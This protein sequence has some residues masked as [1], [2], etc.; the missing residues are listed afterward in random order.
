MQGLTIWLGAKYLLAGEVTLPK[1]LSV[2][3][4]ILI[5]A[6]SAGGVAPNAQAISSASAASSKIFNTIDRVSPVDSASLDGE[7]LDNVKGKVELRNIMHIY[8]SRPGSVVAHNISFVAAAGTTTAIVGA[9]G[10]GKS[11]IVGLLERFYNPVAG[12]VLLDDCDISTLNLKWLRQQISLV[13]QEPV[14]FHTTISYN[15][16]LGLIGTKY[17]HGSAAVK[18]KLVENAA[19]MA[20]A[21]TFISTLPKAYDTKVGER[22]S[23]LSGGQRQRI[24]IAR[25]VISD[26]KLLL[27]DEATSSLDANAESAVQA[28]L[29]HAALGRTTII[30]AH[31]LSTIRS[32]HN[33][34]VL[35]QG[36][37]AEQGSHD[38]LM[39][40]QGLYYNLVK[41]QRLEV[42]R[43]DN[44]AVASPLSSTSENLSSITEKESRRWAFV[45]EEEDERID[46]SAYE[47]DPDDMTVAAK[48]RLGRP[49]ISQRKE[50]GH[51]R[52]DDRKAYST[53]TLLKL[54]G[55]FNRQERGLMLIGLGCSIIA[56]A[57]NPIQAV[58]FAHS[59]V[60]LS[61]PD[62]E[63]SKIHH[64]ADFWAQMFLMLGLVQ[65]LAYSILGLAF[66]TCSE[67][68]IHRARDRAFRTLLRQDIAFFDVEENG[69]GA[70]T[71][72]LATQVTL[73]AG[74]SGAT[75]GTLLVTVTTLVV[76]I[77][78]SCAIGWKLALVCSATVPILIG[79][80]F[81]RVSMLAR[82]EVTAKN[83]SE[84]SA[85]YACE[86]ISS[87]RTVASLTREDEIKQSYNE[88][89]LTQ[90]RKSLFSSLKSSIV[91]AASQ[92]LE[93]LCIALTFWYGGSLVAS[94]EYIELQFYVCFSA[95]IYGALS[96]GV[97]FSFGPDIA[98]G[99]QAAGA[100]KTLFD[101]T[102]QIDWW[103]TEGEQIRDMRGAIEFN[104][105][106][107]H[108][109][110]RSEQ[111]VLNG[112]SFTVEAGQKVALVG[113]SGCGKSTTIALLER[114]Y[115][116]VAGVISVDGI[117]ISTLQLA[118]Y[119]KTIALVSQDLTLFQGT[120]KEN[121][122]LGLE[123]QD[124]SQQTIVQACIDA[125]IYDFI[126]SLTHYARP[127]SLTC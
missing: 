44:L 4:A 78:L 11:T 46:G 39:E 1:I 20:N 50:S 111:P 121:L 18:R 84:M 95:V 2:L 69:S 22:G 98:K 27:L 74:L 64:D 15:I 24:A 102:P 105:V 10:A 48:V 56:G 97:F 47:A 13:S 59:I 108:Y 8:P 127:R 7:T 88:S 25:A 67:R 115:D 51:R 123:D 116:P 21:H 100:L 61:L 23:L 112:L 73:L 124:I 101:Q 118:D 30:I 26:P 126:V 117:D 110:S 81:L 54:I 49:S 40:T 76:A 91:F 77:T 57:G 109:Q 107:F 104:N 94:G 33:I 19:K 41:A 14:L 113:A 114:F 120:I 68:L 36:S 43:S 66:A 125:Q 65:I 12:Q 28:G 75:L 17:E 45:D 99:K 93:F 52:A 38:E 80:G 90:T 34:V 72:F 86:A 9:S 55:S 103:S 119:R 32:A 29:A 37:V 31:R 3:L 58:F 122:L 35:S 79:C 96:A 6:A 92:A 42:V 71:A 60:A 106:D 83:A 85:A 87:I 16:E 53:W 82:F 63:R 62:S 70:L 5:G 89:L